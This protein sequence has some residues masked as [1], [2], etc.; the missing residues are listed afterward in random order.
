MPIQLTHER[1][2]F[3]PDDCF[4]GPPEVC[5]PTRYWWDKGVMPCCKPCSVLP[6]TTHESMTALAKKDGW[7]PLSGDDTTLKEGS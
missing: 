3:G 2:V 7:G 6:T 4:D 5:V 1:L